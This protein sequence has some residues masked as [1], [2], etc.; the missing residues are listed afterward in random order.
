MAS[1]QPSSP[2]Q[3]KSISKPLPTPWS[4]SVQSLLEHPPASLPQYLIFGGI[5]FTA[6]VGVWSWFGTIE[7]VSYAQGQLEPQGNVYKI[8]PAIAGEVVNILVEEG[9]YIE[10]G[11]MLAVLDHRLVE[12]EIQRLEQYLASTRQKLGQTQ[13]LI[14]QTQSELQTLQSMAQANVAARQ[15]TILQEQST[16]ATNQ[17]ILNHLQVDRLAQTDRLARLLELVERGAFA[18]DQ[19]FQVEQAL[20]DRDR[21]IT[22]TQG[23]IQHSAGA[24]AQLEAELAETQAMARKQ[25]LEAHKQ[26]QQLY[27]EATDLEATLKET[28]TLLDRSNTERQQAMLVSPVTGLVSTLEVANIGEVLQPGQT[29]AEIAPGTAPLI[30]SALLPSQEAGL[31]SANMPV[32]VKFDA[33]PYQDYGVV[34]GHVLAISPDAEVDEDTG[35]AAYRVNIVLDRLHMEHEGEMVNLNPGQTAT[36]EIVIRQR[37]ILSLILDPIRKLKKDNISL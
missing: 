4:D 33:F 1:I 28:Q 21:S 6:A 3:P 25:E 2:P 23:S 26:L 32:N 14:Q 5:V 24:I 12:K 18:E 20:R 9:D 13:R 34:T 29:F 37:R 16:V 35:A 31:V 22:E 19:L 17:R 36:A 7:D 10:Q 8:Q 11:Q 27:I 15:S 30:L